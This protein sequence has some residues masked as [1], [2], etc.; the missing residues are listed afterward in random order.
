ARGGKLLL[1]HGWN[2]PLISPQNTINYY[3]GVLANMRSHQQDW[4]RLF[5]EPGME[6]C[7][8]GAGPD[9]IHWM[10]A[11]ARWLQLGKAPHQTAMYRV[12][13]NPVDMTPPLWPYPQVARYTGTGSPDD[14][15]NFLCR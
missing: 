15:A 5:M 3:S 1:Y 13:G 6:H 11:L 2:D 14:A 10:G 7:N 9:Q 4:L 8:G 12:R